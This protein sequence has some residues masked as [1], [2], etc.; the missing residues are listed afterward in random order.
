MIPASLLAL[1]RKFV[2]SPGTTMSK[3]AVVVVLAGWPLMGH[4]G[5]T[6]CWSDRF[7]GLHEVSDRAEAA[8]GV[9]TH[10]SSRVRIYFE[11]VDGVFFYQ[12]N[13]LPAG[14]RSPAKIASTE[15]LSVLAVLSNVLAR[16][17]PGSRIDGGILETASKSVTVYSRVKGAQPELETARTFTAQAPISAVW[18][19]P[20][21]IRDSY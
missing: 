9:A 15:P 19:R 21:L 1:A 18:G 11:E 14:E 6:V 13:Y 7:A 4:A 5:T 2:H 3:M 20:V 8:L 12:S 16:R 10:D 17:V